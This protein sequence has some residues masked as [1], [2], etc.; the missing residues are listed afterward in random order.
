M[1]TNRPLKQKQE[2][3]SLGL[4]RQLCI[5]GVAGELAYHLSALQSGEGDYPL[6]VWIEPK[7]SRL[8]DFPGL[9]KI[10]AYIRNA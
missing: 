4:F 2:N 10:L 5:S 1:M 3:Q 7:Q 6:I 8:I 9:A